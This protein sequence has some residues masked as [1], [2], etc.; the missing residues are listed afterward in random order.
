MLVITESLCEE[1]RDRNCSELLR[2][3]AESLCY[4]EPVEI[5]SDRK[6]DACPCSLRK[7]RG[8]CQAGKTEKEPGA[9]VRCFGAHCRDQRSE[10]SSAEIEVIGALVDPA[11]VCADGD[12]H[13]KIDQ[14][15]HQDT[16]VG[17]SHNRSPLRMN[18]ARCFYTSGFLVDATGL[19]PVTPC[20]SSRYSNQLS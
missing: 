2:I 10:A 13:E 15:S 20:T 11:E 12:H 16:D 8:K 19:E 18:K 6:T 3:Y 7:T 4:E 9:H 5:C 17:C 14:D 1:I